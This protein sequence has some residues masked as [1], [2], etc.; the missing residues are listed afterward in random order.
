MRQLT[1]DAVLPYDSRTKKFVFK[2]ILSDLKEKSMK[3]F[4][5]MNPPTKTYQQKKVAIVKGKPKFYEPPELLAARCKLRDH[6]AG[7]VPDKMFNGPVRLVVK[8]CFHCT[9]NHKD[10]E[11]K[12][13][14]PDTDNYRKC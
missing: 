2:I 10:G 13:T 3:F 5:A 7:Y 4:I 9:G 11:Y 6:L 8:W 1:H 12:Y 14:K